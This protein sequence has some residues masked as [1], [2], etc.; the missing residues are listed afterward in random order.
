MNID[1]EELNIDDLFDNK[2]NI[3]TNTT[4]NNLEIEYTQT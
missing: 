2:L 1:D 4:N 3:D